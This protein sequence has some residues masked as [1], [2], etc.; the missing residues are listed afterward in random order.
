MSNETDSEKLSRLKLMA[1]NR[2]GNWD[3]SPNDKAALRW[4]V[5][6]LRRAEA[7]SRDMAAMVKETE[8]LVERLDRERTERLAKPPTETPHP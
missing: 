1:A 6:E 3:L 8:A 2:Y 5:R 4:A 7:A